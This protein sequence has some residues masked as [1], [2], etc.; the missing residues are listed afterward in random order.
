[1]LLTEECAA[2]NS[3]T[4]AWSESSEWDGARAATNSFLF[5]VKQCAVNSC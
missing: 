1:M 2:A 4:T 5:F 3:T